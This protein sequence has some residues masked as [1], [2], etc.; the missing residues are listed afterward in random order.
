MESPGEMFKV[1]KLWRVKQGLQTDLKK[2]KN[3]SSITCTFGK[4]RKRDKYLTKIG[5]Y[6]RTYMD[7][8]I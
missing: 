8:I 3:N 5:E 1:E 6:N 4:E 7:S 2:G